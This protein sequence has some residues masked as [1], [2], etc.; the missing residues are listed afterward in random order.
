M[1]RTRAS[2][3][4]LALLAAA[5]LTTSHPRAAQAASLPAVDVRTWHPS[6][7]ATAGLVLEAPAVP[8]PWAWNVGMVASYALRPVTLRANGDVALRPVSG[9]FGFDLVA[10]MGLGAHL[11]VGLDLPFILA[12]SGDPLGGTV[13]ASSGV[14]AQALGDL[15]L[16]L[17]A[18]L[19]DDSAAGGIGLALIADATVPTGTKTGFASDAGATL[20]A[21][22]LVEY[23]LLVAGVQASLGYRGR[24]ETVTWPAGSPESRKFGGSVPFALGLWFSPRALGI[25]A[26]G[27]QRWELVFHGSLPGGPVAP[28]G[29][30]DPGSSDL[31]PL[32]L[33]AADR[34]ALGHSHDW[35]TVAAVDVGLDQAIGLPAIRG[36]LSLG[37]APRPH[38]KDGDGIPDDVDQ[39]PED[40]EDKDGFED[41]DG[42]PDVDNDDD[43]IIDK[44][45]ACPNVAGVETSDPTTN[46]C[47][48]ESR[49]PADRSVGERERNRE[50]RHASLP[51][52]RRSP[53]SRSF[54]SSGARSA[55]ATSPSSGTRGGGQRGRPRINP[56]GSARSLRARS[57]R[58]APRARRAGEQRCGR[59]S[60]RAHLRH[61]RG[62]GVD[63][64]GATIR[65]LHVR[66]DS[67]A[68]IALVRALAE[69]TDDPDARHALGTMLNVAAG[70]GRREDRL[71]IGGS[72][73]ER[74]ELARGL[75][76]TALAS[77]H[78][79]RS[80]TSLL[81]AARD[82]GRRAG[83]RS[84]HRAG[85]CVSY[86]NA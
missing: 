2:R 33:G 19:L 60:E 43:G 17:K 50:A 32:M 51:S 41:S 72:E 1:N 21:R 81:E 53:S 29:A 12:Q 25:D 63:R 74:F 52:S 55:G 45:D 85:H 68:A 34:I 82:G 9:S 31:T 78:E 22:A 4:T 73:A 11:S 39:C 24:T 64:A 48:A 79:A 28:F 83:T 23:S 7:D 3:T 16:A 15:D 77:S 84:G 59:S 75:A 58:V 49:R 62:A 14:P 70:G 27:R 76:A 5:A 13:G 67:R 36:V 71:Q 56:T 10:A 20:G 69:H 42:C 8:P 40:P 46:G 6:S 37:W 47:P 26:D 61:S 44:L 57:H 66:G 65:S 38:D 86:R 35:Y 54:P 18:S 30:G 80:P